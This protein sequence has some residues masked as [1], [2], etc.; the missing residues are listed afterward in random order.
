MMQADVITLDNGFIK[1]ARF[2]IIGGLGSDFLKADGSSDSTTYSNLGD[3][4][5]T[6]GT[7]ARFKSGG[8]LEISQITES[9][10]MVV[11]GGSGTYTDKF[12]V[13][14]NVKL[15]VSKLVVQLHN[16]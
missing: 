11:I 14:G 3:I 10:G 1:A 16:F 12:E 13:I 15:M 4:T 2:E 9:A 6:A 5:G 8:G 7:I